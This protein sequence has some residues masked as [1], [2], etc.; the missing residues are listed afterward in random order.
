M[1]SGEGETS[2]DMQTEVQVRPLSTLLTDSTYLCLP[3]LVGED[4]RTGWR[5][6]RRNSVMREDTDLQELV[7][8]KKNSRQTHRCC[9]DLTDDGQQD[10][11][12]L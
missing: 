11:N 1:S 12:D 4:G 9:F 6:E 8:E 3:V 10:T 5:M 2:G 7:M